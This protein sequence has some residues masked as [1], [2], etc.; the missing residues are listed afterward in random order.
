MYFSYIVRDFFLF[1]IDVKEMHLRQELSSMTNRFT[2]AHS[3]YWLIINLAES[4]YSDSEVNHIRVQCTKAQRAGQVY[5]VTDW[6]VIW[7]T[8][9]EMWVTSCLCLCC[10]LYQ[11]VTLELFI[12]THCCEKLIQPFS[13]LGLCLN[14]SQFITQY[15]ELNYYKC[16]VHWFREHSFN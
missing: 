10:Q 3:K 13:C 7:E 2:S 1:C 15:D 16:F 4:S 14:V 11:V 6:T 8:I 5:S 12:F 9:V